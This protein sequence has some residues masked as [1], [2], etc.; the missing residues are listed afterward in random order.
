MHELA[1]H[2]PPVQR[3]PAGARIGRHPAVPGHRLREAR[4]GV[5]QQR[6]R[7]RACA[8]AALRRMRRLERRALPRRWRRRARGARIAARGGSTPRTWR[9][10]APTVTSHRPRT[11]AT[12][13]ARSSSSWQRTRDACRRKSSASMSTALLNNS[14]SRARC[15]QETGKRREEAGSGFDALFSR[16]G[17]R[18][19][20]WLRRPVLASRG[21]RRS[22]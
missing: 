20:I 19:R 11:G 12:G 13:A 9:S 5:R 22:G 2:L 10:T 14:H 21:M 17:M 16:I 6:P 8:R 18:S 3:R 15:D 4:F 1:C 7:R